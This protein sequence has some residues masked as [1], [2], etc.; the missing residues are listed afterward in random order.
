MRAC[1]ALLPRKQESNGDRARLRSPA[2]LVGSLSSI[3]SFA[4]VLRTDG[5]ISSTN[6]SACTWCEY[7]SLAL[8][9]PGGCN[10]MASSKASDVSFVRAIW[11]D[12]P[13]AYTCILG[14]ATASSIRPVADITHTSLPKGSKIAG[15]FG[16]LGSSYKRRDDWNS[17]F[18]VDKVPSR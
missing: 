1:A 15:P 2:P 5:L 9:S 11:A 12:T 18:L 4:T 14:G 7:S 8:P 3:V 16:A 10:L 17:A 13:W 6:V